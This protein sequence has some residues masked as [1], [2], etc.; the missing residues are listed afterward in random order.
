MAQVDQLAKGMNQANE[1]M[2]LDGSLG[3]CPDPGRQLCGCS[4]GTYTHVTQCD[5]RSTNRHSVAAD[6]YGCAHADTDASGPD[7]QL[8][9]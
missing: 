1:Q 9:C 8:Y 3:S 6:L 2:L 5:T 4:A 7:S